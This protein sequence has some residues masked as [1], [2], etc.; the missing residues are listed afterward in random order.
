[1]R[2][3]LI[4][5]NM[6]RPSPVPVTLQPCQMPSWLHLPVCEAGTL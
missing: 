6:T 4:V 5:H 2:A 1:M 3:A